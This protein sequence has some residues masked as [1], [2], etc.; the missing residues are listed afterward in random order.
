M[1]LS[2]YIYPPNNP[3]ELLPYFIRDAPPPLKVW[4]IWNVMKQIASGVHAMH[5]LNLTH[6]DLKPA[7]GPAP[8]NPFSNN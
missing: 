6:R 8:R 3:S 4:Q 7:N 5:N 1:N 2:D